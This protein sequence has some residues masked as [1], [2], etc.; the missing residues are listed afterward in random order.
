MS[1]MSTTKITYQDFIDQYNKLYSHQ[2]YIFITAIGSQERSSIDTINKIFTVSS[3]RPYISI[4]ICDDSIK[5]TTYH[6]CVLTEGQN[7]ILSHNQD[8]TDITKQVLQIIKSNRLKVLI[9]ATAM[10][11]E[12]LLTMLFAFRHVMEDVDLDIIYITPAKYGKYIFSDYKAPYNM[13]FTPGIHQIGLQ[14]LLLLMSGYERDGEFGLIRYYQPTVLL[15]GYAEPPTEE[16]F[17]NRNQDNFKQVVQR[18]ANNEGIRI[19]EF[20]FTG[21]DPVSCCYDITNYLLKNGFTPDKYNIYIAPMNNM[22]TS[23]GAYLVQESFPQVQIVNI[24]GTKQVD[25]LS[26]GVT[27]V[28]I[29]RL[30]QYRKN[31]NYCVINK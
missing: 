17:R 23:I 28:Y 7:I 11:K 9:N 4:I 25:S 14:N 20:T 6:N 1:S 3:N 19:K 26:E 12:T 18:F 24:D 21:N 29:T 16:S 31:E 27:S 30:N 2:N 10:N 15:A 22:L 5:E 8:S 13:S